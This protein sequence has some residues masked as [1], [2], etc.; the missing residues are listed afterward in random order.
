[1]HAAASPFSAKHA[2]EVAAGSQVGRRTPHR[3]Q[4]GRNADTPGPAMWAYPGPIMPGCGENP[5]GIIGTCARRNDQV[6]AL[7]VGKP[8]AH[9]AQGHSAHPAVHVVPDSH[10]GRFLGR[11][12]VVHVVR[13]AARAI[14]WR[15]VILV[16]LA[17]RAPAGPAVVPPACRTHDV[18]ALAWPLRRC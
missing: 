12:H 9:D 18:G 10:H 7:R 3:W 1:M 11:V 8:Q 15:G 6:R 5:G 2:R 17:A 4:I 16:A 13:A 14:T